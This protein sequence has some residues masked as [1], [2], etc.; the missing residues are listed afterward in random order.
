MTSPTKKDQA[1]FPSYPIARVV[2]GKLIHLPLLLWQCQWQ[3]HSVAVICPPPISPCHKRV[4]RER[5]RIQSV[6]IDWLCQFYVWRFSVLQEWRFS[7][8][9]MGLCASGSHLILINESLRKVRGW[10][11]FF[12][13]AV[14]LIIIVIRGVCVCLFV[15]AVF[16]G[17]SGCC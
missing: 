9:I 14:G 1:P 10:W 7:L 13:L 3:I 17:V 5:R 8:N 15:V 2:G 12:M 16:G 4:A 6:Q 11:F